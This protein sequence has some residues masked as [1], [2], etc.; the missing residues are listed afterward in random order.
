[1]LTRGRVCLS[2]QPDGRLRRRAGP[3]ADRRAR[4]AAHRRLRQ[5]AEHARWHRPASIR[6]AAAADVSGFAGRRSRGP[7]RPPRRTARRAVPRRP[8]PAA[9]PVVGRPRLRADDLPRDRPAVRRLGGH[10]AHRRTA[11]RAAR[12]DDQPHLAPEP[13]VPGL[14]AATVGVAVRRSVHHARQGLAGGDP[15]GVDVARIFLRKPNAPFSTVDPIE[16]T[17]ET[18]RD[19]DVVRDSRLVGADRPRCRPLARPAR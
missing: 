10:R 17:G 4:V 5:E 16:A 8:H 13:R 11:R 12:P 18:E 2:G 1:M 9:V 6:R 14:P 7:G 15:A 19:L 3:R